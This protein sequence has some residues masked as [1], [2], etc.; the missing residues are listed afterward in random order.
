[1]A[2]PDEQS[3]IEVLCDAI[4]RR[5]HASLLESLDHIGD[6]LSALD[7]EAQPTALP[8][9]RAA[10]AELRMQVE[11]HLSKEE[12]LLFPA[13]AAL[14]GAERTNRDRP[15]L[16]F[17][18]VI[19]PIRMMESEHLHIEA[20][21]TRLRELALTVGEPLSLSQRWRQCMA[22]LAVVDA[23]LREHHRTE[24]EV[25]FPLALELE[26]RF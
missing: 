19:H 17:V 16:A 6:A 9:V 15:R 11:S 20:S 4:V 13:L 26:R 21:L 3:T 18:T 23:D 8:S 12:S 14:A 1:M 5:Y 25:L 2:R 7:G 24:N 10:F 22:D